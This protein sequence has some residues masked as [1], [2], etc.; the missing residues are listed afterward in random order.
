MPSRPPKHRPNSDSSK[1]YDK[2]RLS[3]SKR[4]YNRTWRRL[5]KQYLS[6]NPFCLFC[7]PKLVPAT[8]VDHII[9]ISERPDLRLATHNLRGLCKPC[10]SR[11]TARDQSFGRKSRKQ[12]EPGT[13]W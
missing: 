7:K 9:P 11:R 1:Q 13:V 6:L 12:N 10:H 8:E 2:T 4:G 3:A 5:R